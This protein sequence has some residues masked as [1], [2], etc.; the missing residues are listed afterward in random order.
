S[1]AGTP[2]GGILSP[3]LANIALS[4][5]DE[6][7]ERHVWPRH[8]EPRSADPTVLARRAVYR[9]RYDRSVNRNIFFPIRYADDFIILVSVPPGPNQEE[10]ARQ[11]AEQEKVELSLLLKERLNLELSETKT[12]VTPV[13]KP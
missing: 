5:I 9:R 1:D 12:L 11:A 3:L 7:Y 2:Q 6:R 8:S 4:V 13:T 10:R